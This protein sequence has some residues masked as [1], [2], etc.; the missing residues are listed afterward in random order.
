MEPVETEME[1]SYQ[2]ARSSA[3]K[4]QKQSL[5]KIETAFQAN[6]QTAQQQYQQQKEEIRSA[7]DAKLRS[8]EEQVKDNRDKISSSTEIHVTRSRKNCEYEVMMAETVE[9]GAMQKSKQ[10]R[11]EVER[12]IPAAKGQ[13]EQI[14]AQVQQLLAHYHF[15]PPS[16]QEPIEPS[17]NEMSDPVKTFREKKE[18][19]GGY[20]HL[21]YNLTIPRLFIGIWPYF[22]LILVCAIIVGLIWLLCR[23]K[24]YPLSTFGLMAGAGVL[25]ALIGSFLVGKILWKKSRVQIAHLYNQFQRVVMTGHEVLDRHL[26]LTLDELDR[27]VQQIHEKRKTE[28]TRAREQ[29]ETVKANVAKRRDDSLAQMQQEYQAA[30]QEIEESCRQELQKLEENY[31]ARQNQLQQEHDQQKQQLERQF[32]QDRENVQQQYEAARRKLEKRWQE[33]LSCMQ[34][35]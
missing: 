6:S 29:F 35:M 14:S 15:S 5:E 25:A 26:Q 22:F 7:C 20:Y 27:R 12:A 9:D 18:A 10:E 24:G 28:E 33:G 32:Q 2:T 17:E 31:Q 21:L 11:H 16:W 23:Q 3:E 8:L 13:L 4:K 19:A 34:A 1:T 30:R